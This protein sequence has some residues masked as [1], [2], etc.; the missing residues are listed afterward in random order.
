MRL[1]TSAL[2][3]AI[4]SP[5]V[6][7]AQAD[8]LSLA[9]RSNLMMGIGLTGQRSTTVTGGQSSVTTKGEAA[10]FSFNHWVRPEVGI[11]ISASLLRAS[12]TAAFG[13]SGAVANAIFPLLFGLTYSPRAL[14]LSPSI[15]PFVS[16]AAGPY[17]HTVAGANPEAAEN[18]SETAFGGRLGVGANW[19]V[20]RHFTVSVEA[21]HHAVG[22]F[23]RQDAV[24]RDPGGFGMNLGFGFAWG[25]R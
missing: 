13:P 16:A 24:T 14:A 17:V 7:G 5:A 2:I 20:A 21:N 15:R 3:L 12:A 19:F 4:G 22:R 1:L 8:T 6:A 9:G 11:V 18:Y 25:A 10:S 23:E